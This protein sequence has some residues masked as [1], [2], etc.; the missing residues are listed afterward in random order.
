M[1]QLQVEEHQRTV[2]YTQKFNNADVF[3]DPM[4]YTMRVPFTDNDQVQVESVAQQKYLRWHKTNEKNPSPYMINSYHAQVVGSA[5]EFATYKL[6]KDF[7]K[8][9][10]LKHKRFMKIDPAFMDD[11]R[12]GECDLIVNGLRCEVKTLIW[13]DWVNY[14][15][16]ITAAQRPRI[17][18]KADI[19]IWVVHNKARRVGAVMGFTPVPEIAS[20][21]AA[22]TGCA[23]RKIFNHSLRNHVYDLNTDMFLDYQQ[24]I[25]E[26]H[27]YNRIIDVPREDYTRV[28]NR[29]EKEV[30]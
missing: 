9:V 23:E 24:Y 13:K 26:L 21:P 29:R 28:V 1:Y 30:A 12:E 7:V 11:H 20:V 2:V 27:E 19:I 3:V 10:A 4:D 16:C 18:N 5:G 15:P 22:Y 6:M 14:G 17:E 25:N 8:L